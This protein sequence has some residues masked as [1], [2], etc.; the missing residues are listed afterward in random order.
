MLT[1]QCCHRSSSP[2]RELPSTSPERNVRRSRRTCP[3]A[4]FAYLLHRFLT[5]HRA[6]PS[7]ARPATPTTPSP[8]T[9]ITP[10]G[11]RTAAIIDEETDGPRSNKRARTDSPPSHSHTSFQQPQTPISSQQK[12]PVEEETSNEQAEDAA[13]VAQPELQVEQEQETVNSTT[14]DPE[15]EAQS[16]EQRDQAAISNSHPEQQDQAVISKSHLHTVREVES[17]KAEPEPESESDAE[18]ETSLDKALRESREAHVSTNLNEEDLVPNRMTQNLTRWGDNLRS[19][20]KETRTTPHR[21]ATPGLRQILRP[22]SPPLFS[23]DESDSEEL[24]TSEKNRSRAPDPMVRRHINM[25]RS[26]KKEQLF[27]EL[28]EVS[29]L[30]SLF[31]MSIF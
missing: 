28:R 21:I 12:S 11:K 14:V 13:I 5:L 1:F 31:T 7:P 29:R 27:A 10:I 24:Y 18:T 2:N 8:L 22:Q 26:G 16:I 25:L 15:Q 17:Q 30:T 4:P 23:D 6:P 20:K 19:S 9:H 3:N